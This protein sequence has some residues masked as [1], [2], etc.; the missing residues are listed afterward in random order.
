MAEFRVLFVAED[1]DRT[2]AFLRDTMGLTVLRSWEEGGRGTIF[3]AADGQIEVFAADAGWGDAGVTG[4][5]LAW[6][7][8]DVDAAH[9]ELVDRGAE[10]LAPPTM[11]PWGHKNLKLAG[12]DGWTITLFEIVTP[13]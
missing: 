5:A 9:D 2:T 3:I 4:A 7:V 6:E 12:P 8:D 11:Q 10:I 1:Y 13:Q